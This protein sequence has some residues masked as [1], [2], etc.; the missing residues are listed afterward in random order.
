MDTDRA[1]DVVKE[2][3]IKLGSLHMSI[4]AL[5]AYRKGLDKEAIQCGTCEKI[6]LIE[7]IDES[8]PC[9]NCGTND[10]ED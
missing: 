1:L 2:T 10:W 5:N 7:E 9:P 3:L 8:K 4:K 6:W